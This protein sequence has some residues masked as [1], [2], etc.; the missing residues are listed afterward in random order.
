MTLNKT[1]V[2]LDAISKLNGAS[3]DPES[4]AY[5]LRNPLLIKSFAR[6]G[7][8]ETDSQGRRIFS[9]FLNGYKAG[10]F[11]LELKISGKSRARVTVESTLEQ[12]LACYEI[13]TKMAIEHVVSFVRRALNDQSISASTPISFFAEA[14]SENE[15]GDE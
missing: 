1:E 8:H 6:P 3:A 14:R 2:L 13:R 9:S 10:L 11:D 12:L 5:K 15:Q 7:K 4:D